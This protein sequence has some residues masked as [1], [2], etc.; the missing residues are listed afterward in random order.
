MNQRR[1]QQG[2]EDTDTLLTVHNTPATAPDGKVAAGRAGAPS[3]AIA[4]A[5][6][7]CMGF[8]FGFSLEKGR[9]FEP[10][11]I[12]AQMRF[13][14]F[15]MLKM[16]LGAVASSLVV[17]SVLSVLPASRARFERAREAFGYTR[18][19]PLVAAG[20]FILGAGMTVAGACPGCVTMCPL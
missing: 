12:V 6:A 5:L 4:L 14:Q 16:F 11:T 1:S 2:M 17:L 18:G 20:A 13:R 9:V 19:W 10:L 8:T 3:A 15:L 7:V